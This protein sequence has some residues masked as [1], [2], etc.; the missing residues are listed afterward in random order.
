MSLSKNTKILIANAGSPSETF[1]QIL[2]VTEISWD[3][4]SWDTEET[5]NHDT[6]TKVRTSVPTLYSNGN[7][8]L[9]ITFDAANTNHALLRSLATTG[10]ARNF[11]LHQVSGEEMQFEGFVTNFAFD[12][13]VDG[14]QK[15]NVTVM[16]NGEMTDVS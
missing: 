1:S 9:V 14:L 7:I 13:P 8:S 16:V 11:Q 6:T 12:T 3:G 5:T 4:I 2:K 15:A 10:A